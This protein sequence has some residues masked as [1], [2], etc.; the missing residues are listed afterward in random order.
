VN[1]HAAFAVVISMNAMIVTIRVLVM[2][3]VDAKKEPKMPIKFKKL[4]V[5]ATVEIDAE[6]AQ[7]LEYI[8]S[9][10][11][12]DWFVEKC[13]SRYTKDQ[14]KDIMRPIRTRLHTIL[15]AHSRALTALKELER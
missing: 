14:L 2:G 15:D 8:T 1:R 4:G 12:C 3:V 6:T 11:L 7:I 5:V 9:Y 13:S 10:D